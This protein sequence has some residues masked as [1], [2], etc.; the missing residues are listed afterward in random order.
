MPRGE[1]PHGDAY[2]GLLTAS[3]H[4][5][6]ED[7]LGPGWGDSTLEQHGGFID[8]A[9]ANR[10]GG[11]LPLQAL[12]G[13]LILPGA[14]P[15]VTEAD[16]QR[17][18][19]A[20]VVEF[21]DAFVVYF[22]RPNGRL[23][24]APV[25]F[26]EITHTLPALIHR[27]GVSHVALRICFR[28]GGRDSDLVFALPAA[29]AGREAKALEVRDV[30]LGAIAESTPTA[31][32]APEA[33]ARLRAIEASSSGSSPR[34][35]APDEPPP[36]PPELPSWVGSGSSRSRGMSKRTSRFLVAG[37]VVAVLAVAGV[38]VAASSGEG[39]WSRAPANG[40]CYSGGHLA[41]ESGEPSGAALRTVD[42]SFATARYRVVGHVDGVERQDAA[43]TV[44]EGTAATEIAWYDE[45]GLQADELGNPVSHASDAPPDEE[46]T[47]V[48]LTALP[49]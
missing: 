45:N 27:G 24:R 15:F 12:G 18:A 46:G 14:G 49:D 13:D 29:P 2:A 10:I 38:A 23:D 33:V 22:A 26:R 44:C 17:P 36:A 35:S 5:G 31:Q 40:A 16:T 32:G 28:R 20:V 34:R 11:E 43:V 9:L 8:F 3:V 4:Q 37:V 30:L 39:R 7:V 42:C 6:G 48:C 41:G 19:R 25:L 21:R 47:V 1:P